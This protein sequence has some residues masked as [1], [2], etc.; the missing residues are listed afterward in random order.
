MCSMINDLP[1]IQVRVRGEMGRE[2]P[3]EYSDLRPLPPLLPGC[4]P[5]PL[6]CIRLT[7]HTSESARGNGKRKPERILR[8]IDPGIANDCKLRES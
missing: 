5:A 2:N 1:D 7:R 6:Y 8:N 4:H 3:T